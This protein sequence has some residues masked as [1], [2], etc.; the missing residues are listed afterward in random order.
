MQIASSLSILRISL[1]VLQGHVPG[2]QTTVID[3]EL[4]E[5]SEP[6]GTKTL[7]MQPLSRQ[8]QLPLLPY[9]EKF[10]LDSKKGRRLQPNGKSFAKGTLV[11]YEMT[12]KLLEEF[13]Q[14]KLF[15]LRITPIRYLNKRQRFTERNYWKKFY[16]QFTA[17]LYSEKGYFDNSTGSIIKNIKLF[18]NYLNKELLLEIGEFHKSFYVRKEEIPIIAL[19]PEELNYLIYDVSFE[20]SLTKRLKEAKD[21]FVFGCTVGLRFSDLIKLDR[22]NI[23]IINDNWWLVV[24]AKK[25]GTDILTKLPDYAKN[26]IAKYEARGKKLLPLFNNSN[27]STYLKKLMYAAGF[28]HEV[29]KFREKRGKQIQLSKMN[30]GEKNPFRFCDLVSPHTMRRT[31]IS[32][33]LSLGVPEQIVRKMVGHTPSSKEFYR[34][35]TFS[36]AYQDNA[37]TS[38]FERLK[39][40]DL[41]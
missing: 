24:R 3:K 35:V 2:A 15:E 20:A 17:F 34:Y 32:T 36:Q 5:F 13:S 21:F 26:I 31:S 9:F 14:K 28:T 7:F 11:N 19:L 18:F 12:R 27:C 41:K 10:I 40:K 1:A 30:N 4:I 37:M 29:T 16:R 22:T 8:K 33:M 6:R 23:R 39:E 25:T 38:M